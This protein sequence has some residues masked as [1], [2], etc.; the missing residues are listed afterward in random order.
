MLYIYYTKSLKILLL[1]FIY[2]NSCCI[3]VHFLVNL[4]M[5]SSP[6]YLTPAQYQYLMVIGRDEGLRNLCLGCGFT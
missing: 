1:M 3:L 2:I 5:Y 4:Y 6:F